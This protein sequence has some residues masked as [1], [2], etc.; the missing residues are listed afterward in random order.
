MRL[1]LRLA[2]IR[3]GAD[4]AIFL[5]DDIKDTDGEVLSQRT[6]A[7][8]VDT[9]ETTVKVPAGVLESGR[10]YSVQVTAYRGTHT[11]EAPSRYRGATFAQAQIYTGMFTP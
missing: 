7:L 3:D 6:S 8:G 9:T 5:Q 2:H 1:A 10:Y 11:R 4:V